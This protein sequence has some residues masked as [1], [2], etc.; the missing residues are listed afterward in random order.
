LT[1]ARNLPD[2][3]ETD[4]ARLAERGREKEVIKRRLAALIADNGSIGAFIDENVALFNGRP[5]D[6]HSFDL[7]DSLLENQCYRLSYW[8][9]AL[10]E[11]NYRRFF[12]INDLAALSMERPDVFAAAHDLVMRLVANGKVDGLRV[13]HPDGLYNPAEYFRR[14]QEH[15]VIACARRVLGSDQAF[16][17]LDAGALEN[18][19][20]ERLVAARQEPDTWPLRRCLYVVAEKILGANEPLAESWAVHGTSGYDFLALVNGLFVDTHSGDAFTR[21]YREL[22]QDD[23][24]FAEVAHWKKLLILDVSLASELHMLTYQLD[25]LAQKSRKSRDFTFNTLRG[26]LRE[27]IASFPV[28]RPYIGDEGVHETDRRYVEAAVRRASVRNPVMSWRVLRFVRDM[29]LLEP[30]ASFT[31]EDRAEQRRFAGK[32]QQVTAP[33]TAKGVEDTAFYIYNRLV[34]L[35]EVGGQPGRFGTSPEALHRYNQER[36]SKWPYALSPLST[37]DTKRSEDVRARINVLSEVPEEW[38]A[39]VTRWRR[40][41]EPH[42]TQVDDQIVPDANEEYPFY[43]TLIGAWPLEPCSP[44]EYQAFIARIRAYM[45]KALHEA[46]VHT[47][48]INPNEAYDKAIREFIGRALCDETGHAFLDDFRAFERRTSRYGLLNSLSQTLLKITCPGVPDTYQGTEIWDFS[49]VDPDNRRPV[50]YDRRRA[51]LRDLQSSTASSGQD[52]SEL[53]RSLLTSREDGRIKL[54]VTYRALHCR[55]DQ[56]SLFC[57]G[58]YLPLTCKGKS[59]QHLFAFA[60]HHEGAWAIVVVPRLLARLVPDMNDAPLG[61]SV[62]SDTTVSLPP[63]ERSMQWGNV[64]TGEKVVAREEQDGRFIMAADALRHFPVAMLLSAPLD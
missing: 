40:L 26:A 46:K 5:G 22:V 38:Q 31:S 2:R 57:A 28:Y 50:D 20:K 60:R 41:N 47:S 42:R 37:H 23:P 19:L 51:M 45:E 30:R 7:L 13:D 18:Q 29:L 10:D 52:L 32:F 3:T 39:C 44:Q 48:W 54:Y 55:R 15:F 14:L 6:P 24:G 33:V 59:A 34:S 63:M 9:V 27:V 4:T 62:W 21:L 61:E 43:Q 16:R 1:A 12:D 49:L 64:F 56:A 11:I 17:D 25:R 58:E 35:N 53:A 8:R 36:Q